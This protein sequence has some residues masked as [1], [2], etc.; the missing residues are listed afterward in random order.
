M[1]LAPYGPGRR[2]DRQGNLTSASRETCQRISGPETGISTSGVTGWVCVG[3]C[4]YAPRPCLHT[5]ALISRDGWSRRKRKNE[6][7]SQ[8]ACGCGAGGRGLCAGG[9]VC[10]FRRSHGCRAPAR[11]GQRRSG[12]QPQPRSRPFPCR[13][14]S[15]R[16]PDRAFWPA[17]RQAP[18]THRFD[19]AAEGL[20][21]RRQHSMRALSNR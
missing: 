16:T 7:I 15:G 13:C 9:R 8:C 6:T 5:P 4:G 12:A 20:T 17:W 2:A 11:Y 1:P 10:R 14:R 3:T 21:A 19:T 18:P